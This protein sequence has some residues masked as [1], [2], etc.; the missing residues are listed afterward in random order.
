MKRIALLIA[1]ALTLLAPGFARSAP[2][3][4]P[5]PW[6]EQNRAMLF[7]IMDLSS[8]NAINGINLTR[9]Q[10]LRLRT[11]A[12]QI[13]AG[14]PPLPD[15]AMGFRPDLGEVRD[16][17]VQLRETLLAGKDVGADV[18]KQVA[19]ARATEA[20]VLRLSLSAPVAGAQGCQRCHGPVQ[21][22]DV[23]GLATLQAAIEK[24]DPASHGG[25]DSFMAHALG[26]SGMK[27][28]LHLAKCAEQVDAILTPEQ[29][30]IFGS[31]SCCIVPPRSMKDPVRA[32]QAAGGEKEVAILRHIRGV[33]AANWP[34]FR[35]ASLE[36]WKAGLVLRSPDITA[37]AKEEAARR[38]AAVYEEARALPDTEFELAKDQL[39][40][41]LHQVS[42]PT[43]EDGLKQR[44][45]AQALFLVG[46]GS[47]E[48]YDRLLR[49]METTPR[50]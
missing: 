44:R 39:A 27:G 11:L 12:R 35:A 43:K 23:R 8:I 34:M 18:E 10:A 17:Y 26:L 47:T 42:Q 3:S 38:V 36:M 22:G 7:L 9:D 40:A 1:A 4:A 41:R 28:F 21:N 45:F 29:K 15:L 48:A 14:S 20:A 24:R 30:E 6:D 19:K 50:T 5:A 31:F 2:A 37:E 13:D 46:P 25:K 33:P 16:T 32:G 49:R